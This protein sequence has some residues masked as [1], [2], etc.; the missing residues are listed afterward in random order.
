MKLYS[1]ILYRVLDKHM[2]TIHPGIV[3]RDADAEEDNMIHDFMVNPYCAIPKYKESREYNEYQL[4]KR[5]LVRS[6]TA[7]FSTKMV[8]IFVMCYVM[9]MNTS[10]TVQTK[11]VSLEKAFRSGGGFYLTNTG[12]YIGDEVLIFIQKAQ[13]H[14]FAFGKLARA[15]RIRKTSVQIDCD[16]Y[17]NELSRYKPSTFVLLDND[18]L[19]YFSLADLSHILTEA[20]T[21]SY[22]FCSEPLTAKNPY[23]NIPFNVSTL[24]NIYLQM[25][26]TLFVIPNFFR[27]YFECGFNI[28]KFKKQNEPELRE[29]IVRQYVSKTEPEIIVPEI[30]RMLKRFDTRKQ[31][32]I[33]ADFPADVLVRAMK[34]LITLYYLLVY[35]SDLIRREQYANDLSF[36]MKRFI[37][38]NPTFGRRIAR[39]KLHQ[40]GHSTTND[41]PREFIQTV[42]TPDLF[43]YR[44]TVP[45]HIYNDN[46]YNRYVYSG[47]LEEETGSNDEE[48]WSDE[49]EANPSYHY[50]EDADETTV[51][52][53]SND[54]DMVSISTRSDIYDP[55]DLSDEDEHERL[56][57]ERHTDEDADED[58]SEPEAAEDDE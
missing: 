50:S 3:S 7:D 37:Q 55:E 57:V 46:T 20:L 11:Y 29:H 44:S 58:E 24:Y 48:T 10:P 5:L 53:P 23:N 2:E 39:S 45:I 16:L 32:Y 18:K 6:Q 4:W 30:R 19:Y 15:F 8:Y 52:G 25:A 22:L 21:Y 17:M 47:L 38:Y 1:T 14:Y 12:N 49:E 56:F 35:S 42:I 34:P 43:T 54:V 51:A 31:L 40:I 27:R 9:R 13:R 33:D 36:Q 28:Y 26:S 41:E